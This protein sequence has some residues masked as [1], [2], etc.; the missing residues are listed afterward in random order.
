[1]TRSQNLLALAVLLGR[2]DVLARWV[3]LARTVQLVF[4]AHKALQESE[5]HMDRW[6]P[7]EGLDEW[8]LLVLKDLRVL[9]AILVPRALQALLA[10]LVRKVLLGDGVKKDHEDPADLPDRLPWACLVLL[11]LRGLPDPKDL[12]VI[13]DE[14]ALRA[15]LDLW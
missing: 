4:L 12:R 8:V 11:V 14:M 5:A 3:L 2:P 13:T 1:M 9:L 6:V 15:P 7:A 10:P